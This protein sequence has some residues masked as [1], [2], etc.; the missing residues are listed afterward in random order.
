MS[1]S[2]YSKFL[3][4]RRCWMFFLLPV[5]KLSTQTTLLP[6]ARSFSHK[7]LPINP[8]PPVTTIVFPLPF[9]SLAIELFPRLS[10][11]FESAYV[12]P[13]FVEHKTINRPLAYQIF[14]EITGVIGIIAIFDISFK[15]LQGIFLE[16][17]AGGCRDFGFRFLWLFLKTDQFLVLVKLDH[18]KLLRNIIK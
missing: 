2:I 12:K 10:K 4:E 11:R 1:C 6:L 8:A 18:P 13:F 16:I 3:P 9:A 15:K 17:I 7:W 14:Y 5:I